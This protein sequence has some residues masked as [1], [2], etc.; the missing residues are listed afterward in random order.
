[1]KKWE[2]HRKWESGCG[3]S[4]YVYIHEDLLSF[5]CLKYSIADEVMQTWY[6]ILP[7]APGAGGV[8]DWL[9]SSA[10]EQLASQGCLAPLPWGINFSSYFICISNALNHRHTY[11]IC[12]TQILLQ[13]LSLCL[14]PCSQLCCV[15]N[16]PFR[17][18]VTVS[19][20]QPFLLFLQENEHLSY[21]FDPWAYFTQKLLGYNCGHSCGYPSFSRQRLCGTYLM[22]RLNPVEELWR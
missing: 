21:R 16:D 6:L 22:P 19:S 14:N 17:N 7:A 15:R 8:G 9:P 18:S 20:L 5:A 3:Q 4:L 11:R 10:G 2:I 1:M 12:T 13:I